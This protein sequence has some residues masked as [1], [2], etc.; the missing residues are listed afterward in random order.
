LVRSIDGHPTLVREI[1]SCPVPR[2]PELALI[3]LA[4]AVAAP[5]GTGLRIPVATVMAFHGNLLRVP[6]AVGLTAA[7]LR[8]GRLPR[9]AWRGVAERL[10][11]AAASPWQV[12]TL[13]AGLN[14]AWPT[15]PGGCA[16]MRQ[17]LRTWLGGG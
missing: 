10:L 6:A 9:F 7:F 12:P 14:P 5:S 16:G 2:L 3:P 8:R 11:R 17:A 15:R 1:V 13:P 4:D